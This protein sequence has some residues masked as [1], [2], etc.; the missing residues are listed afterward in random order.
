MRAGPVGSTWAG[1]YDFRASVLH[2]LADE[3]DPGGVF[4]NDYTA[5]VLG[6]G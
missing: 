5:R 3:L 2:A 6:L 4:R 1:T